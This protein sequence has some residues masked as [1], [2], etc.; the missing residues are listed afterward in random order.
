MLGNEIV[1]FGFTFGQGCAECG[2]PP[3]DPACIDG[4]LALLDLPMF[5]LDL[6]TA[7]DVGPVAKWLNYSRK[8]RVNDRYVKLNPIEAFDAIVFVNTVS[9]VHTNHWPLDYKTDGLVGAWT[10]S[11]VWLI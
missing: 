3:A 7:P 8:S 5:V 1:V 10:E 4:N 6:G 9:V 11:V 2:F